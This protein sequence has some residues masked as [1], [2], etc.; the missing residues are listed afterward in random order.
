MKELPM[1][2]F[3]L[4]GESNHDY[5]ERKEFISASRLKVMAKSPLHYNTYF[6]NPKEPTAAQQLGTL[7]HTKL[8]EPDT[9]AEDFYIIEEEK[10]NGS[11]TAGKEQKNRWLL[12]CKG[13]IIIPK[14]MNDI[15]NLMV[16]SAL[17][18]D[19]ISKLLDTGKPEQSIYWIDPVTGLKCKSRADWRRSS[20][21]KWNTVVDLKTA[22]DAS[23]EGF[24]KAIL[25]YDYLTQAGM[26]V[27]GIQEVEG[28][29]TNHYI[30]IAIENTPPYATCCYRLNEEDLEIG[31]AQ[32]HYLL[33][34]VKECTDSGIWPGY[35]SMVTADKA[36][37]GIVEVTFPGWR[38]NLIQ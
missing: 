29:S 4:D 28:Y 30:Y 36:K 26:Q 24:A 17:S 14:E 23:P 35:E 1:L 3:A 31:R 32:F 2:P 15:A 10:L 5:H 8:L 7:V 22:A 16:K 33:Q 38:K 11:T 19:A 18:N 6:D 25:S 9:L 21:A 20:R 37:N 12:E 34:K 27:V 13:R